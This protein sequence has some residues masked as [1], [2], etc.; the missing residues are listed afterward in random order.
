MSAKAD[1]P[2]KNQP[3]MD[4][5]T[6]AFKEALSIGS[7]NVVNKPGKINGF[8]DDPAIHILLPEKVNLLPH[9]GRPQVAPRGGF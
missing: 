3:G 4:E 8:N 2:D 7:K 9:S 6:K 1:R 5:I